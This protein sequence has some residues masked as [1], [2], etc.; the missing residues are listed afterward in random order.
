M[1]KDS[2]SDAG[3]RKMMLVICYA[4]YCMFGL[5]LGMRTSIFHFVQR[6]YLDSY[7]HI[8]TL[9]LVSG[10]LMQLALYAAGSL[11]ERFGFHRILGLGLFVSAIS[12]ALMYLVNSAL[13]FDLTYFFFMVGFGIAML[14]LNLFVSHLV[15]QRKGNA[16]LLLHL[17]FSIGALAGPYWIS[18][19]TNAGSTWQ[20]VTALS[21]IPMFGILVVMVV[22]GRMN[23]GFVSGELAVPEATVHVGSAGARFRVLL[24]DPFVWLFAVIFICSQIW[25]YGIGTW[26]VIF[27]SKT[28]GLDAGE[29]ALYLT[30]FYA[31]YPVI[32]I[33]FSRIIHRLNLLAVL[34]GAFISC[35]VFGCLGIISGKLIFYSLTGAGIA[36]MYPGIMAAMQHVFGTGSTKKI[37]FIT[38]AG[39]MLQYVAIWSVGLLSNSRGIGFGFN[40]MLFY[41]VFG[42]IAAAAIMEKTTKKRK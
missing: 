1:V 36:L 24:A 32:R 26:F 33:V 30:L 16:L 21:T 41:L 13:S 37:G 34:T 25:E 14:A 27:A 19:M 11:S 39:G 22:G 28:R 3:Y 42:A 29:A 20:A 15:P 5:F 8:A 40:S 2:L 4:V 7:S 9:I 17:F 10:V 12:L 35:I 23:P 18:L 6:D 38:M 31:S